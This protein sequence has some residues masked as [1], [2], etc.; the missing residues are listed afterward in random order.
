VSV[1]EDLKLTWEVEVFVI[2][3]MLARA[4]CEMY[5]AKA[6]QTVNCSSRG[7]SGPLS[8]KGQDAKSMVVFLEMSEQS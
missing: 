4:R 8:H 5:S 6:Q 2:L 3:L 1:N 7:H